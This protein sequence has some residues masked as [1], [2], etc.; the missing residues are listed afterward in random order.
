[1]S[2]TK[3][4]ACEIAASGYVA[5]KHSGLAGVKHRIFASYHKDGESTAGLDRQIA[6]E[7]D[8]TMNEYWA[9][10]K[11][12][13]DFAGIIQH[14]NDISSSEFERTI[15]KG[16]RVSDE[17]LNNLARTLILGSISHEFYD[18][19]MSICDEGENKDEY[20]EHTEAMFTEYSDLIIECVELFT[21]E[22]EE[23]NQAEIQRYKKIGED[24]DAEMKADMEAA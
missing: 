20:R 8:V 7:A 1:M 24:L 5:H 2:I 14:I 4:Q 19:I 12:L 11:P 23:R 18:D 10:V 15:G 21:D 13:C 3:Y 6:K 16:V 9:Q 22:D 17:S